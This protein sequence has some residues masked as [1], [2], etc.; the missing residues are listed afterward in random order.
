MEKDISRNKPMISIVT[1]CY[2]EELNVPQ[3]ITRVREIMAELPYPYEHILIDNHSSD[4][5]WEILK[6]FAA[7]DK[8]IK[9]IRNVR[10]FGGFRSPAYALYQAKGAAAILI[11]SDLQDPPELIPQFLEKWE[12]GYKVVLGQKTSAEESAIMYRIRSLYYKIIQRFSD[13]PEYA[14][15]T[16]FGLF[17][18]EVVRQMEKLDEP[19]PS[20]RHLIADL[21]YEAALVPFR[22]PKRKQGKTGFGLAVYVPFALRSLIM[23]S[24][25]PLVMAVLLGF[26]VSLVSFGIAVFYLIYKLVNW[27]SFQMGQ[28][29]ILIGIFFIG[30]VLLMFMGII[31]EYIGEV[32]TRVTKRPLVIEQERVNFEEAPSEEQTEN[33][34]FSL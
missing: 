9:I 26:M 12:E 27:S 18:Q 21:G 5:T 11:A 1:P 31:G 30:G 2:N 8:R 14:H 16:G 25:A 23:T 28:A 33:E 13:I 3:L 29:P 10:N 17:D 24:R 15:V 32:L 22:Q 19:E 34:A 7:E 6:G 20:T 4:R